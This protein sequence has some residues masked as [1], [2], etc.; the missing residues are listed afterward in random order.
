MSRR[1]AA[2][3]LAAATLLSGCASLPALRSAP[4][5]GA[6][7][8]IRLSED[9][10]TASTRISILTYNIEGLPWPVRSGRGPKLR[11]IGRRLAALRESGQA[12]NIVLF[13]EAFS[14]SARRAV[15]A[16]G[17]PTLVPGPARAQPRPPASGPSLPGRRQFKRGEHGVR[18]L[19]SGLAIAAEYPLLDHQPLPFARC[20]GVDCLANKGVQFARIRIPGVPGALDLYNTHMNSQDVSRAPEPRH[21]AAHSNQA[22]AIAGFIEHHSGSERTLVFGGDLNMRHAEARFTEFQRL[23]PLHIVHRWCV[24]RPEECEV[25]LSWDGDEP[26]MDTQDLQ[27]F[28]SGADVSIRPVRVEAMFDGASEPRLSDH[29]GFLVVY[30]LSWPIAGAPP[31]APCRPPVRLRAESEHSRR[32]DAE[33]TKFAGARP[34]LA[35]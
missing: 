34:A 30:E 1:P 29:D 35:N 27:L 16:S 15:I 11:E 22:A 32:L 17:Y 6:G 25:S 33:A 4:C 20:A 9:G 24:E 3:V 8:E 12:P 7:P 21:T 19:S 28:W 10:A 13:Q 2:L 31:T 23:R 18:L 26:W 5:P 14:R